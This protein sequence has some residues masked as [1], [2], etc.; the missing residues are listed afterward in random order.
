MSQDTTAEEAP[1]ASRRHVENLKRATNRRREKRRPAEPTSVEF[2][3]DTAFIGDDFLRAEVRVGQERHIV[4]A[5]AN[6]LSVLARSRTWFLDGTFKV[7]RQPFTQLFSIHAFLRSDGATKQVPL[8][9][10]L[11]SRRKKK[12]YEQV[13]ILSTNS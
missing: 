12:D 11:M 3:V 8:V 5:T 6:Q 13:Q 7:V 10:V 9:F 4:F 2:D 1:P